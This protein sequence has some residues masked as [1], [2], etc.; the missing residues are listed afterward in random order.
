[1][2]NSLFIN[3]QFVNNNAL[4]VKLAMDNIITAFIKTA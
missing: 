2:N 1:M 3:E 4:D